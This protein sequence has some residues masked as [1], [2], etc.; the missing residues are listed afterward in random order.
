MPPMWYYP[1]PVQYELVPVYD[2]QDYHGV[3]LQ[4]P[5]GLRINSNNVHVNFNWKKSSFDGLTAYEFPDDYGPVLLV[6][7]PP[8]TETKR[9]TVQATVRPTTIASR[10]AVKPGAKAVVPPQATGRAETSRP[11]P[12]RAPTPLA[13]T[14][15]TSVSKSQPKATTTTPSVIVPQRFVPLSNSSSD[16]LLKVINVTKISCPE[17]GKSKDCLQLIL[18]SLD[19]DGL[20]S[21]Q[22]S[23]LYNCTCFIGRQTIIPEPLGTTSEYLQPLSTEVSGTSRSTSQTEFGRP[24]S[25]LRLPESP[26]TASSS[27]T[28]MGLRLTG[29]STVHRPAEGTTAVGTTQP[30]KGVVT[31][32]VT[33]ISSTAASTESFA[34]PV[35]TGGGF[36]TESVTDSK[37]TVHFTTGILYTEVNSSASSDQGGSGRRGGPGVGFSSETTPESTPA[38]T[39][40]SESLTSL[41]SATGPIEAT[42]SGSTIGFSSESTGATHPKSS[43]YTHAMGLASEFGTTEANTT[44]NLP[45]TSFHGDPTLISTEM[46]ESTP[47]VSTKTGFIVTETTKNGSATSP[48]TERT[49]VGTFT[50]TMTL[51]SESGVPVTNTSEAVSTSSFS[52]ETMKITSGPSEITS[53]G[54]TPAVILTTAALE[55]KQ[56]EFEMTTNFSSNETTKF[57]PSTYYMSVGGFRTEST[58]ISSTARVNGTASLSTQ[59][60]ETP[61]TTLTSAT[62]NT[63]MFGRTE[64]ETTEFRSDTS[65]FTA[66][67]TNTTETTRNES[68]TAAVI[69]TEVSPTVFNRTDAFAANTTELQL[70]TDS[71]GTLKLRPVMTDGVITE[72][73]SVGTTTELVSH[74]QYTPSTTSSE[75]FSSVPEL[76]TPTATL[77]KTTHSEVT[78]I[79]DGTPSVATTHKPIALVSTTHT[80]QYQSTERI[81]P[82]RSTVGLVEVSTW[83][84]DKI[85]TNTSHKSEA[86]T[87]MTEQT[88]TMQPSPTMESIGVGNLTSTFAAS[89]LSTRVSTESSDTVFPTSN[90]PSGS[91]TTDEKKSSVGSSVRIPEVKAIVTTPTTALLR[92]TLPTMGTKLES[93]SP[94]DVSTVTEVSNA[95]TVMKTTGISTH[96]PSTTSS[97]PPKPIV[98]IPS[99]IK[100]SASPVTPCPEPGTKSCTETVTAVPA[101]GFFGPYTWVPILIIVILLLIILLLVINWIACACCKTVGR[102]CIDPMIGR[103]KF[104]ID[105]SVCA[106]LPIK[107]I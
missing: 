102:I 55:A 10:S 83:P 54:S 43:E 3:N 67:V 71:E 34:T 53:S 45:V 103:F 16:G 81:T 80:E 82:A 18:T 88:H 19:K 35:L 60:T 36:S 97:L 39:S 20:S 107:S 47:V 26:T 7:Q 41:G 92:S 98:L 106:Y 79:A 8:S 78:E 25:T 74:S 27:T 93:V 99:D 12:Q 21:E 56:T 1:L 85:T 11:Q 30:Y 77:P 100:S 96:P 87:F 70:P 37:T 28:P 90:I 105:P 23:F 61:S 86:T 95:T 31:T 49:S 73:G 4:G 38:V 2:T 40:S 44:P 69:M 72:R 33:T 52:S 15:N 68:T 6:V 65:L 48:S 94:I 58:N 50:P 17:E 24:T 89:S 51:S 59:P 104:V 9:R 14:V 13:A 22:P 42:P 62:P 32:N 64:P 66:F 91:L 5:G 101:L 84:T 75:I 76:I 46:T 29:T 57:T 63:T